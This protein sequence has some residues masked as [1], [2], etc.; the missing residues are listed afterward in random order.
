MKKVRGKKFNFSLVGISFVILLVAAVLV[1]SGVNNFGKDETQSNVV[2]DDESA[3]NV[4]EQTSAENKTPATVETN[5][6][7]TVVESDPCF[8]KPEISIYP[9]MVS[10][11]PNAKAT[12]VATVKNT[13]VLGCGSSDFIVEASGP[14]GWN[15]KLFSPTYTLQ[16]G[17]TGK[18]R[19]E[20][21]SVY[22]STPGTYTITAT[23]KD[24]KSNMTAQSSAVY[25]VTGQTSSTG[26]STIS[27]YSTYE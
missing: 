7:E 12:F 18:T 13:Q 3:T 25:N 1:F 17:D 5:V 20:A 4:P 15:I 6:T 26:Q 16:W 27:G 19:I 14:D 9:E 21:R 23:V 10:L 8:V 2:V 22:T 24:L 11:A